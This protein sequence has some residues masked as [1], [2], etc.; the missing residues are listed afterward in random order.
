MAEPQP[1]WDRLFEIASGYQ[2][3]FSSEHARQAGYSP[4]LLRHHLRAGRIARVRR[5]I[6]RIVHFP[7]GEI[8]THVIVWLWSNEQGVFSHETALMFHNLSDALPS[9]IHLT[10]PLAWKDRRITI[11]PIVVP[12][13]EDIPQSDRAWHICVPITT[14]SRTVLDCARNHVP[15]ELVHQALHEGIVRDLFPIQT[16][17]D[18]AEFLRPRGAAPS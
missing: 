3:Y 9:K 8:D 5:G 13:F 1:S 6:Y 15:R 12:Y 16:V 17:L 4:Q 10:L 18:A 11:P 7:P 14:P 2:G